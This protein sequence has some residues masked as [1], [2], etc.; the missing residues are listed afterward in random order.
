MIAP[1]TGQT[2]P[3]DP[4]AAGGCPSVVEDRLEPAG[5][6]SRR[7][8]HGQRVAQQALGRHQHQRLG[9]AAKRGSLQTQQ[10][11]VLCRR[12]AVRHY[13]VVLGSQLQKALEPATRM[14]RALAF[15]GVREQQHH[16]GD[17]VPLGLAG[18]DE[19]V[20]YNLCRVNEVTVLRLP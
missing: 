2:N 15:P 16:A 19:L 13:D 20:D 8:G 6:K 14:V 1:S 3:P 5:G 7:T 12:S 4:A 9:P 11:E 10:V 18:D 17:Q